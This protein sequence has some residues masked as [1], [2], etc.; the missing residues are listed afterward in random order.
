MSQVHNLLAQAGWQDVHL[1]TLVHGL[2]HSAR[3]AAAHK[4]EV[5]VDGP[6]TPIS[7][8]QAVPLAMSLTELFTNSCKHGVHRSATGK[9]H[10]AWQ[11]FRRDGNTWVRLAW[12]ES[13][14]PEVKSP[15][16]P[17]LGTELI[18]DFVNFELGGRCQLRY[19]PSDADHV[20]EFML[21]QTH[22]ADPPVQADKAPAV[23]RSGI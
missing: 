5:I 23:N 18:E 8:R 1:R 6:P 9:V 20:I 15:V 22:R 11:M 12:R 17:S 4:I 3:E 14:G 16:T 10:I 19:P 21:D 7:P 13:G 2:V